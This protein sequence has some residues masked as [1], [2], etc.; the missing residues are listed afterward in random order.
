MTRI[1]TRGHAKWCPPEYTS[2]NRKMEYE[3][4]DIHERRRIIADDMAVQAR[5]A[6]ALA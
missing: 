5:R 1:R 3:G 6:R 4:F 2:L